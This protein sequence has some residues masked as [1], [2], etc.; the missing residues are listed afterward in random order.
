MADLRPFL[1]S[2]GGPLG[3]DSSF[4]ESKYR[5]DKFM[6]ALDLPVY[7]NMSKY[8]FL[9]LLEALSF[10]VMTLDHIQKIHDAN[11]YL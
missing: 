6:A 4:H 2:L 5:Q 3:F 7:D 10:R 11:N 8:Q 9:D 1:F